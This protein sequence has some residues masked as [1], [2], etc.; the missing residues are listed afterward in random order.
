[1]QPSH[2]KIEER[3]FQVN[4]LSIAAVCHGEASDIPVLALH[5]WLDNAASF[6]RL[7]P[8]LAGC[9]TVAI[10]MPG[11][12][13]TTHRYPQGSY[14]LWD[15]LLDLLALADQLGWQRFHLLAHSRGAMIA[16]LLAAVAPERICS[17]NLLDGILPMPVKAEDCVIQLQR[18]VADFRRPSRQ[19]SKIYASFDDALKSRCLTA[20][21]TETTARPIVERALELSSLGYR[22]R[23]DTRVMAASSFKLTQAHIDAVVQS[24]KVPTLLLLAE[25]GV[26]KVF[27]ETLQWLQQFPVVQQRYLQGSHH[28]H[29]EPDVV[30]LI[31]EQL[32]PH[33]VSHHGSQ[34]ISNAES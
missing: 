2:V 19:S 25:Q 3:T 34:T 27:A 29:L 18:F 15:D 20:N 21:M 13:L 17:L 7:A 8:I 28:F 6:C 22:W 9:Y 31:A 33:I 1:M 4:G 16:L 23:H 30:A 12:G 11:Q 14:N 32:L 5:G 26:M 10:D 24:L